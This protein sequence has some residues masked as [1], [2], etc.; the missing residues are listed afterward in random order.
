M[1]QQQLELR[2]RQE[3]ALWRSAQLRQDLGQHAQAFVAPLALA[4]RLGSGLV[5]LRRHPLALAAV[6][7]S[8]VALA[9][10]QALP[11]AA[12]LWSLWCTLRSLVR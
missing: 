4:D 11:K 3:R 6:V 7:A 8:M 12:R 2:V 5:W 1:R 10:R 9:P